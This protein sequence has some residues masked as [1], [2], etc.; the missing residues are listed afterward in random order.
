MKKQKIEILILS[1][2]DAPRWLQEIERKNEESNEQV[3]GQI[4][5]PYDCMLFVPEDARRGKM[6]HRGQVP[7]GPEV[8]SAQNPKNLIPRFDAVIPRISGKEFTYGCNVVRQLGLS[9][10]YSTAPAYALEN[11]S[12][13]WKTTQLLA[14]YGLP[15]PDQLLLNSPDDYR[16]VI[17]LLDG[18]PLVGKLSRGSQGNGVFLLETPMA[19]ITALQSMERLKAEITLNRFVKTGDGE[20]KDI[21][22]W[23]IG[24]N[25]KEPKLF[26]MQRTTKT[27]FRT[28][29]S[30]EGTG[31]P[32]R[33]TEHEKKICIKSAQ[34]FNMDV[35][36]VDLI[37]DIEKNNK[38]FI[39]E[40]NGN[41]GL[42]IE[43]VLE[44]NIVGA[45]IDHVVDTVIANRKQAEKDK[46][47]E[48]KS[49][50]LAEVSESFPNVSASDDFLNKISRSLKLAAVSADHSPENQKSREILAQAQEEI[51][52]YIKS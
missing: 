51:D 1:A 13:K 29:L 45:V 41:P 20:F 18:L 3:S 31:E 42:K 8:R 24:C 2:S 7:I 23:V 4:M 37:R 5:H 10:V 39:L 33:L 48:S 47:K 34:I 16:E 17:D 12:N 27:D 26:A 30:L 25:T 43:K 35:V 28:N 21:R 40:L 6:Y 36:A 15:V 38:S 46:E 52:K 22:V 11:C 14:L 9:K 44:E 50:K 49:L 19:A 32:I